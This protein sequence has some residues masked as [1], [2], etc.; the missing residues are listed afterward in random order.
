MGLTPGGRTKP[1]NAQAGR[2]LFG[3]PRLFTVFAFCV[4]VQEGQ[5]HKTAAAKSSKV[6]RIIPVKL[7]LFNLATKCSTTV[8]GKELRINQ[9]P[10]CYL[11][12]A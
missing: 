10:G 1:P 9:L 12:L 6:D 5:Q 4:G 8:A 7:I 3:T 11:F 2:G